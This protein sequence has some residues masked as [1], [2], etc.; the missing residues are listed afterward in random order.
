MPANTS[1][2]EASREVQVCS[3]EL[4]SRCLENTW[5]TSTAAASSAAGVGS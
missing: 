1:A 2:D 5:M 3:S 4:S